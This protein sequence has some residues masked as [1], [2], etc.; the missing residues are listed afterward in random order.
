MRWL[1]VVALCACGQRHPAAHGDAELP[2]VDATVDAAPG[3]PA[4]MLPGDAAAWSLTFEDTFTAGAIDPA[5]WH[6]TWR[7]DARSLPSN[8]EQECYQDDAFR[9]D[10]GR[11]HILGEQRTVTCSKP[12]GTYQFTSG[13]LASF[14]L[15]SQQYGYFEMRARVPAGQGMWPA[16]WLMPQSGA[17]P[18][19]IDIVELVDVMTTSYHT[20]HYLSNGVHMSDGVPYTMPADGSLDFHTFAVKWSP[21]LIV[22][23]VDGAEAHRVAH[24]VP[25][26]PF[27]VLLNLAIGGGW[28]GNPD[29]TTVFP[30]VMD[31]DYVRVFQ[32][33]DW[34]RCGS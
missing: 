12:A 27:Y 34:N 14:D 22:W 21:G 28:P 13:A 23:Y 7:Y 25:A 16:F 10:G 11:L 29:Q 2:E 32:C 33:S 6:T 17:W 19:E 24:D 5:K 3:K 31:V 26:E 15:F 9:F 18:P 20:L 8:G 30:A 1:V 4:T